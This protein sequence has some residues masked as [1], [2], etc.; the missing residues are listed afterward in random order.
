MAGTNTN[1]TT[2]MA[3]STEKIRLDLA[4]EAFDDASNNTLALR[5]SPRKPKSKRKVSY[6][7]KQGS[8]C[9]SS[10]N[11]CD[12]DIDS[13]SLSSASTSTT[14]TSCTSSS[15]ISPTFF[16]NRKTIVA[17]IR[18]KSSAA[19]ARRHSRQERRNSKQQKRHSSTSSEDDDNIIPFAFPPPAPP[20]TT[21]E[22]AASAT[23]CSGKE[24]R[25]V[26]DVRA[27]TISTIHRKDYTQDE[28]QSTWYT[29][30]ELFCIQA[31]N[32]YDVERYHQYGLF[33]LQRID[34]DF[35]LR[36]LERDITTGTTMKVAL[37]DAAVSHDEE[38]DDDATTASSTS[39]RSIATDGTTRTN[40]IGP[41]MSNID[42][43]ALSR[44]AVLEQQMR[45]RRDGST[46]SGD[47]HFQDAEA[48][49]YAY[50]FHTRQTETAAYQIAQKD[51]LFVQQQQLLPRR[52]T[53]RAAARQTS[54]SSANDGDDDQSQSQQQQHPRA[55]GT[56]RSG[57]PPPRAA[58]ASGRP[59]RAFSASRGHLPLTVEQSI[60]SSCSTSS[61]QRPV[62]RQRSRGPPPRQ[63]AVLGR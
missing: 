57:G 46:I 26:D 27:T 51:Q 33:T 54:V 48:I 37:V 29:K 44:K 36:G 7:K 21:P 16:Q 4:L 24:V 50:K 59:P 3:P 18:N 63:R 19:V 34:S 17:R 58:A 6:Q 55:R 45:Q 32:A 12:A 47:G 60:A 9:C 31:R 20:T 41:T 2:T 43:A 8:S 1:T 22:G 40:N 35:E 42:R 28:V 61:E 5:T 13:I 38:I 15:S 52:T 23:S 49:A 14:V 62:G 10:D 11:S 30:G 56:S 25:F 53:R 39:S